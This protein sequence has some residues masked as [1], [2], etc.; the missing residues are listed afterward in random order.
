MQLTVKKEASIHNLTRIMSGEE[1][2]VKVDYCGYCAWLFLNAAALLAAS[3]CWI[4]IGGNVA[5][6]DWLIGLKNGCRGSCKTN[7][8]KQWSRHNMH[9]LR[10]PLIRL[11]CS[12]RE[13]LSDLLCAIK[14]TWIK[15]K[16]L[17]PQSYYLCMLSNIYLVQPVG[18]ADITHM[19]NCEQSC[20][21]ADPAFSEQCYIHFWL[22]FWPS[23]E[24]YPAFTPAAQFWSPTTLR[25][26]IWLFRC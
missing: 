13:R 23:D 20:Q 9:P 11:N 26:N 5:C 1:E 16:C 6:S 19:Y 10:S 14:A 24:L 4:C 25:G 8:C 18:A 3:S 15:G 2:G 7:S 12:F 22:L 21:F 17:H